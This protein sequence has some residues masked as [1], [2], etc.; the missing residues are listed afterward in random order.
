MPSP[1][2]AQQAGK[3]SPARSGR[4]NQVL[5]GV[6][7]LVGLGAALSSYYG[8]PDATEQDRDQAER[9]DDSDQSL[10]NESN[11]GRPTDTTDSTELADAALGESERFAELCGAQLNKIRDVLESHAP[12][13]PPP[14]S[15]IVLE[16]LVCSPLRPADLEQAFADNVITVRRQRTDVV[17]VASTTNTA[18]TAEGVA[19]AADRL[20]ARLEELAAPY[21]ESLETHVKFKVISVERDHDSGRHVT[22]AIFQAAGVLSGRSVQQKALWTCTWAQTTPDAPPQLA[23]IEVRGFEEVVATAPTGTLFADCTAS[24]FQHDPWWS[25]QHS[26]GIDTFR[27]SI[28]SQYGVYPFGHHG[29]A[30][31]DIN[32]D[33]LEDLYVCQPAGLPN[34]LYLQSADGTVRDISEQSGTDWLDRSR[35]ALLIDL[36]EDGDCDLALVVGESLLLMENSGGPEPR[37]LQRA[38]YYPQG[39]PGSLAAADYDRDGDLD[40]FVVG[41]GKRFLS[42]GVSASPTPYHDANNGGPNALLRNNGDW[43][44]ED[45]TE[46]SGLNVN[47]RRWSLAASWEDFDD[48]GDQDLYVANDFGRNNLYRN[49]EG[50][51]VDIAAEA[52]VED[53]AA[54]MSV[55]W[56]DY[57]Q[58]GRMDLY[59]GNMF[60]S[61]GLRVAR[62]DV[63]QADAANR[64]RNEFV[65]HARGN[66]LFRNLGDGS[67]EDVSDDAAVTVGRWAWG[68]KFVDLNND[69]FEDIVVANGFVTSY[70][71]EDL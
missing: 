20:V 10:P 60:S 41:Y 55:S 15:D 61:A 71:I 39:D 54:G 27:E 30:I 70:G 64:E 50:H 21:R 42:D 26:R 7:V 28:Q 66:S 3:P 52:G 6:L 46:S 63:F 16:S 67:F 65:R 29:I 37:F 69:G 31:G 2:D 40:L 57:D 56:A 24:V 23:R 44:F 53:I 58:D 18:T 1:S 33:G 45:V 38:I 8:P 47:N 9:H 14:L 12:D 43:Q 68:S 35:G 22:E 62:Q 25:S 11:S 17:E 59:V 4:R 34:R 5:V 19:T 13:E 51:F 36:D 48:D 49:D 32:Q